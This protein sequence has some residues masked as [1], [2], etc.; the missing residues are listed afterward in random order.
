MRFSSDSGDSFT[1]TAARPVAGSSVGMKRSCRAAA[2]RYIFNNYRETFYSPSRPKKAV[3]DIHK[4]LSMY[5]VYNF[6]FQKLC[7]SV[8]ARRRS[9]VGMKRSR[10]AQ[11]RC[12]RKSSITFN[13]RKV[14]ET[15]ISILP[16]DANK[17]QALLQ[18]LGSVH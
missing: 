11:A 16:C 1:S 4:L 10:R 8:A 14:C 9:G 15:P 18:L 2:A 3:D 17:P 5:I 6:I 7:E 12:K 13:P